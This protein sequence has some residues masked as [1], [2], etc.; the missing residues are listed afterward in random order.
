[1]SE[2]RTDQPVLGARYGVRRH[3]ARGGMAEIFLAHDQVLDRPVAVKVLFPKFANDP[4]F[5]TRFRREA[6]A[7]AKLNHPGSSCS[8]SRTMTSA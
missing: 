2:E 4:R 5:V 7:A 6:S 1:M 8:T 3:L